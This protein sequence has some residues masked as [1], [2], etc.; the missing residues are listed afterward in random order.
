M[1]RGTARAGSQLGGLGR[2]NRKFCFHLTN[3]SDTMTR[4]IQ[5]SLLTDDLRGSSLSGAYG[6]TLPDKPKYTNP[7]NHCGLCCASQICPAGLIAMPAAIAPCPM[8]VMEEN[9]T[10]CGL[11]LAEETLLAEPMLKKVLGIGCGCS[12]PDDDTTE[13][14][15]EQFDR[16]S[17][18]IVFG[19]NTQVSHGERKS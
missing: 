18:E 7:C 17:Y 13:E 12:M 16:R 4:E 6:S 19:S 14:E 3:S 5:P 10:L 11:V 2:K 8:L 9:K 15:M 1:N